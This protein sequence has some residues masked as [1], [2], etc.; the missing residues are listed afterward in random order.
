MRLGFLLSH[1]P[2]EKRVALLPSHI[3]KFPDEIW[4]EENFGRSMNINDDEYVAR[5]CSIHPRHDIFKACESIFSLTLIQPE[6][7]D[8]ISPCQT[9]IGWMRLNSGGVNFVQK[10]A[11]PK[12]LF[13]VDLENRSPAIYHNSQKYPIPWIPGGYLYKN[14]F[15]AGTICVMHACLSLG[16]LINE[17]TKVAILSAGNASQGAFNYVSKFTSQVR[18]FY[19]NTM[20][21]FRDSIGDYDIIINGI[22]IDN[23]NTHIISKEMTSRI[24]KG[25][26]VIDIAAEPDKAIEGTRGTTLENPIYEKDGRYYYMVHNTPSLFYRRSSEILS[27]AFSRYVFSHS[28]LDYLKL[29]EKK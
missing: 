6:K 13:L 4:I 27:E 10:Q 11:L 19:R 23:A 7:Y 15:L 12:A 2:N 1:D 17:Q 28:L 5:G 20:G 26:L 9:I 8:Y 3:F 24:K 21:D 18:L 29:T 22:K 16:F 14:S 25:G